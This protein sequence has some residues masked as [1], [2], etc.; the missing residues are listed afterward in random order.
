MKPVYVTGYDFDEG[1]ALGRAKIISAV[2]I[3]RYTIV[4]RYGVNKTTLRKILKA[5]L[6]DQN[7]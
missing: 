7:D 4:A 1:I 5:F 2:T 6:K 3:N